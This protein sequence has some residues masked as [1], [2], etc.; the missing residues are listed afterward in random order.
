MPDNTRTEGKTD[1]YARKRLVAQD[2]NKYSSPKYRL[3]VRFTNKDVIAQLVHAKLAGDLVVS[4]AHAQE[5]PRYGVKV[6][7]KNYSAAYCIG[8]LLA[9]RHLKKL[10]L[11]EKYQGVDKADGEEYHVEGSEEGPRPFK[12]ILDVGLAR[13]TTGSKVFSVVKGAA[14]GGLDVP[15]STRRFVGYSEENLDS[16][17]LRAHIFGEHVA[18]Y[19]RMCKEKNDGGYEKK[20]SKYISAGVGPDDLE[21]MYTT[22]HEM[23]RKDPSFTKKSIKENPDRKHRKYSLPRRSYATR[24]NRVKQILAAKAKGTAE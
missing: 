14:D 4:S 5:L 9:R 12:A 6:G 17:I 21:N 13:T 1:Y 23:I 2:K 10:G 7:L 15:H 19:M 16:G 18:N 22:A 24:K 3:V 11:D 8:L 20:F